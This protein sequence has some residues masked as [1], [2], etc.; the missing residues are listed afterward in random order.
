MDGERGIQYH[1]QGSTKMWLNTALS[2]HVISHRKSH[3]IWEAMPFVTVVS[4][5]CACLNLWGGV[6]NLKGTF[7]HFMY[8]GK[9]QNMK[10]CHLHRRLATVCWATEP[11]KGAGGGPD[12]KWPS[13]FLC[14]MTGPARWMSYNP[15]TLSLS[16]NL[17][18]HGSHLVQKP[19]LSFLIM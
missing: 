4:H 17:R 9:H 16:Q 6:E 1:A 11:N 3:K 7:C 5:H 14:T 2:K 15:S 19:A 8:W 18:T 12:P 13:P 10:V